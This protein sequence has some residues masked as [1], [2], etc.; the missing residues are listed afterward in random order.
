MLPG[1]LEGQQ[2]QGVAGRA[3]GARLRCRSR[4]RPLQAPLQ[5]ARSRRRRTVRRRQTA[6][7]RRRQ[8]PIAHSHG[9][10]YLLFLELLFMYVYLLVIRDCETSEGRDLGN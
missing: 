8:T 10:K 7:P 2:L 3:S 6:C 9:G 4:W 5:C 1:S